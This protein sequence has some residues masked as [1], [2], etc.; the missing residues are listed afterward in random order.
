MPSSSA[1]VTRIS[2]RPIDGLAM[3]TSETCS[4]T[5]AATI[6]AIIVSPVPTSP[7][8]VT[9]PSLCST[10]QTIAS[11]RCP[12]SPP[13]QKRS[14]CGMIWKGGSGEVEVAEV[15]RRVLD[16]DVGLRAVAAEVRATRSASRSMSAGACEVN[17]SVR[18]S[19]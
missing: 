19:A 1:I 15:Q 9:M 5:R 10:A 6:H 18:P 12:R 4:G 16:H 7:V 3:Q 8:T 17:T 11:S 14:V 13:G 2:S